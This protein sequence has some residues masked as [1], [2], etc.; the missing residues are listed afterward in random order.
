MRE[1]Q[2]D[3][4]V[5][6]EGLGAGLLQDPV[7]QRDQVRLEGAEELAGVA[8]CGERA[9]LDLG[10]RE[11]QAQQLTAGVPAGSGDGDLRTHAA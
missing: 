3:H 7:G 10:M 8:A 2:E 9:D 4:V 5:V 11:Q 6:L 1:C